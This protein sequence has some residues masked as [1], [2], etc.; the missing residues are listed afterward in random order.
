MQRNRNGK[1]GGG[2]SLASWVNVT[3]GHDAETECLGAIDG[4]P[5]QL[6]GNPGEEKQFCVLLRRMLSLFCSVL[7]HRPL[8][9]VTL[10]CLDLASL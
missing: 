8:D 3:F 7:V 4:C 1:R 2:Y 5:E 9:G 6:V 10:T